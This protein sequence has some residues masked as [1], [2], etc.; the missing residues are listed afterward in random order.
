MKVESKILNDDFTK[1][2][3]DTYDIQNKKTVS[4]EI[5]R[6]ELPKG[7]WNI[8]LIYGGS[9]SGKSLILKQLGNVDQVKFN[10]RKTLVSNFSHM[11]PRDATMLLTSVGLASV[12]SWLKPYK[13]LSNGE[14]FRAEIAFQLSQAKDLY[15]ID[16]FTSVVDR[17]VAKAMSNA[18]SKWIKRENKRV[19]LASCHSDIVDWLQPDWVFST[20]TKVLEKK[21]SKTDQ[22][23]SLPSFQ[24]SIRRGI[25]SNRITI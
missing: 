17:N 2:V 18:V 19:V 13:V 24:H 1:F 23:L 25:Y 12:P 3:Y 10:E 14:K 4:F 9:G 16:E 21:T 22:P 5:P 6:F 7:N 8:G 15:L 20:Q 11:S